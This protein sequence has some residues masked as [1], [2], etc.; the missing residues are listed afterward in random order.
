MDLI[1]LALG[2]LASAGCI[3]LMHLHRRRT[4]AFLDLYAEKWLSGKAKTHVQFLAW[5]VENDKAD[6]THFEAIER[7]LKEKTGY[8]SL[9]LS[10]EE[11]QRKFEADLDA[12][13]LAS[14][15]AARPRPP[16]HTFTK[17]TL[18]A[19]AAAPQPPA[20]TYESSATPEPTHAEHSAERKLDLGESK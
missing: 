17:E 16:E 6:V 7:A 3:V 15:E 11:I 18:D 20:D 10:D 2:A 12:V 13:I 14:L 9:P 19:L 8:S 5:L 1:A 4:A